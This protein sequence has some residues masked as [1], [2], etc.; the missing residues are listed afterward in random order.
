MESEYTAILMAL[1][2]AIPV[3]VVIESVSSELD[4]HKHKLLTFKATVHKDNQSTLILANLKNG[5]H[6][7]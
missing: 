2:S 3:L 6:T 5:R 4:Y 1:R 7:P